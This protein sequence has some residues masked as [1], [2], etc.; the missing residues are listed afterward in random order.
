MSTEI[1]NNSSN[2][3]NKSTS[4]NIHELKRKIV[5]RQKKEKLQKNIVLAAIVVGVSTIGYLVI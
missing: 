2:A 5:L 1:L 4:V 3:K